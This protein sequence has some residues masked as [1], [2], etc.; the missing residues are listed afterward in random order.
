MSVD[1]D[2]IFFNAYAPS[3]MAHKRRHDQWRLAEVRPERVVTSVGR[4]RGLS[5]CALFAG[6]VV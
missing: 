4:L 6:V 1:K 2:S 3:H 5:A